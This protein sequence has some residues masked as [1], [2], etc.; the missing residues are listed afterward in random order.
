MLEKLTNRGVVISGLAFVVMVVLFVAHFQGARE[1][2]AVTTPTRATTETPATVA[3]APAPPAP[4]AV[5]TTDTQEPEAV[6]EP[7]VPREVTY[8]EAEAAYLDRR[9]DDAVTLFRA[10]TERKTEN[11]WG[12]YMLGLSEWKSGDLDGAE[13]AFDR[14][15]ELDPGHVK[16]LVNLSRVLLDDGRPVQAVDKIDAALE[17]DPESADAYR[18]RGRALYQL[19]HRDDAIAAY[20]H[21]IRIDPTDAWS[22]NNLA[23]VLIDEGRYQDALP[24]LAR[25]VEL[26]DDVAVF[27]NNLGMALECTGHFRDA[28]EAY[29]SAVDIDSSYEKASLNF[30]RASTVLEEPGLEPV[31]LALLAQGFA[32]EVAGWSAAVATTVEPAPVAAATAT[33][34]TTSATPER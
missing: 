5:Q 3:Q 4:A 7:E 8:E 11:A 2:A 33:T 28:V 13:A 16:S 15:L 34:D 12:H 26:R 22:M 14:A 23:L 30:A 17:L 6:A 32:D 24:P 10:Y 25:A 31:D 9:Y 20:R 29:A 1:E 27:Y 18:L 21:A 19:G